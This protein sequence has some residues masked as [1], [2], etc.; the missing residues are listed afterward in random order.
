MMLTKELFISK[1]KKVHGD[2]FDYSKV[3]YIN[4]ITKVIITCPEHGDFEQIPNS[5]LTGKGCINC[6]GKGKLTTEEFV[7]NAKEVHGDKYDYSRVIYETAKK[8]VEIICKKHGMFNQTPNNHTQGQGCPSC[9]SRVIVNTEEFIERA[10]KTHGDMYDYS[11][12]IYVNGINKVIIFCKEHGDFEQSASEHIRGRGCRKCADL[13]LSKL[14]TLTTE[15]FISKAKEVHGDKFD[16][17]KVVYVS[18]ISRIDIMCKKHGLFQQRAT[19]HLSGSGCPTC[20]SSKGE[21]SIAKILN[22][23]NIDY[24]QEYIIPNQMYRFYYDFYLPDHNLLIEYHGIQHYKPIEYFGGESG[25]QD[26]KLRDS[27]KKQLAK[28]TKYQFLEIKY[29]YFVNS[30]EEEFEEKLIKELNRY[31]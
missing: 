26:L 9:I 6:G 21:L 25:F 24:I 16:Y 28:Y 20:K 19:N 29:I 17:S 5:H 7:I 8:P 4:S 30:S 13:Y 22:K 3:V 10:R 12:V 27:F 18:A 14:N 23:Y 1:A 15:E 11:K 2:K 31:R